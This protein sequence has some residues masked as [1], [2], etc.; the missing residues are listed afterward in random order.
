MPWNITY[1][2]VSGPVFDVIASWADDKGNLSPVSVSVSV[3]F[4]AP[5]SVDDLIVRCKNALQVAHAE[6]GVR[7][8]YAQVFAKLEAQL[9]G[10]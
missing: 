10:G 7:T 3:N 4:E 6:D 5:G 1:K 8:K 2:P 9:N